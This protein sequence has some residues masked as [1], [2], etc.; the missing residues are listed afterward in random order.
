MNP[1]LQL[2]AVIIDLDGTMVDTLGDFA[3]AL[4][5]ML[6]DLGLPGIAPDAIR[7]MVG[8]GSEHLIA[9]V[10]RQVSGLPQGAPELAAWAAPA[11]QSYQ[12]HYLAINGQFSQCYPGVL[13]GLEMLRRRGLPLAC[14]TNKP[15]DF[16]RPL[17]AS[18]GLE[19]YFSQ[20]FGGDSFPKKKPDPLPL[21]K[22]CEALGTLPGRTLMLGDSSNDAQA[23]R[24]AG[25][26]V[27]L[28]TYGYNHGE[29][30]RA[31]DADGFIGSFG[32]LGAWLES[33]LAG[34]ARR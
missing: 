7:N 26:P 10:L 20:V 19:G 6:A 24:A 27:V 16:T 9:S 18:L 30:V 23:A 3:A 2:D 5:G 11:W 15:L 8:K 17:L 34:P 33:G 28:V 22:T 29:P 1:R 31:V 21:R 12:K 14:L 4:N 25:C 13:P 32:E